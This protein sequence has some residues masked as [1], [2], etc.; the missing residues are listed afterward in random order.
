MLVVLRN[1]LADLHP[2]PPPLFPPSLV[3]FRLR[4][5]CKACPNT[6]WLLFLMFALGLMFL[7][8]LSV[9]LSRKRLNLAVLGIGV[10]SARDATGAGLFDPW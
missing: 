1:T 6:A 4:A 2:R 10:V 3:H 7:V 9:Y 8:G 5:R